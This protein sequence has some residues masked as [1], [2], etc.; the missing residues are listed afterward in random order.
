VFVPFMNV[1]FSIVLG[2]VTYL[3][4][5]YAIGGIDKTVVAEIIN[6]KSNGNR[7]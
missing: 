4:I 2:G 7:S 6:I 3:L 1:P 5:L